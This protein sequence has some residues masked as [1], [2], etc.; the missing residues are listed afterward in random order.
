MK[1]KYVGPASGGVTIA[2]TGQHA[3]RGETVDVDES[4]ARSLLEQTDAWQP[5]SAPKTTKG[6]TPDKEG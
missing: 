2:A 3:P 5:A 6:A 1:I 4:T